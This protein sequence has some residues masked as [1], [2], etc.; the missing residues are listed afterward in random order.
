MLDREC[1]W[2]KLKDASY[3]LSSKERRMRVFVSG[4]TGLLG[5][6]LVRALRVQGHEVRA[7]VRS[8][9]K[10]HALL[11]GTGAEIVGGDMRDVNR[12][13]NALEGID[14]VAHTAAY[15][16]EYYTP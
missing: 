8:K 1:E 12:F 5:N 14:A 3:S 2:Q 10:A 11:G 6:N 15:F 9:R 13:E 7:L 4:G 16:R